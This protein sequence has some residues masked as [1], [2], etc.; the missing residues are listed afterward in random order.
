VV[1]YLQLHGQIITLLCVQVIDTETLIISLTVLLIFLK[2]LNPYRERGSKS[3]G[4]MGA[5]GFRSQSAM[6]YLMTYG[7]AILAVAVVLGAMLS[8]ATITISPRA[9]PGACHV[10]RPEGPGTSEYMTLEGICNN[11][12]PEY[13]FSSRG[14]GD[15]LVVGG[16]NSPASSLNIQDN[17]TVMAWV[18]VNG[19]PYHDIVDK[20]LQYG[21]KLD[22]NNS[23]HPC[24]PSNSKGYCLEWDTS[25]NWVGRSYPIPNGRYDEWI[26]VAASI[27]YNSI[28][29]TSNKRAYANGQL[30][31]NETDSGRLSYYNSVYTIGAI[32]P[33]G[34]SGYGDAEWF[35]GSITNVQIYNTSLDPNS[36]MAV[37]KEGIG[38]APISLSSLIGWWPLNDNGNDYGGNLNNGQ[39]T[40]II[41]PNSWTS[42]YT[43]P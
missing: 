5:G 6:E 9:A 1:A 15:Y 39:T 35:N 23:P 4:S 8:V 26:F 7:W 13:V 12:L 19:I 20:E 21:L 24:S 41:Y 38:G 32:S 37:Y 3:F 29:K 36:V 33:G 31:G 30:L 42:G 16:S 2:Y 10:L 28:S 34:F 25:N 14:V 40:N 27:S 43:P 11:E 18:Y 22:D 17:L